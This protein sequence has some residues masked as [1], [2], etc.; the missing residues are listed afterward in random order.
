[1]RTLAR[2]Y[3]TEGTTVHYEQYDALGHVSSL[4]PWLPHSIAWIKQRFAGLPAPQNCSSIAPGNS[5]AP[6]PVP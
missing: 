2:N 3:C 1:V 5:L 6:I 4:V